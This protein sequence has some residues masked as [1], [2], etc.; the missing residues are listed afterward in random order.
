MLDRCFKRPHIVQALRAGPAGPLLDEFATALLAKGYAR[1]G[2]A[3]YVRAAAHLGDWAS[4]RGIMIAD[5]DEE[6][7]AAFVRH[8][9]K[10]RCLGTEHRGYA[11]TPSR[12]QMFLHYLQRA[13]LVATA[14]SEHTCA[15]VLVDAYCKWMRHQRGATE[16]TISSYLWLIR[17][18]LAALGSDP[19]R[20]NARSI[21]SFVLA[22]VQ[23]HERHSGANVTAAVRSFLR[24]LV[25]RGE[26]STDLI[27][28]VPMVPSRRLA[29][30]PLYLHAEAIEQII[31]ACPCDTRTGLRDR[32][33]LLLLARIG[34][35]A[36]DVVGL[37]LGDIDWRKGRLRVAGK[38]RRETHLPLPQDAGDAVLVYLK[39]ARPTAADDHVFLTVQAPFTRLR[40]SSLS[41]RVA[42]AIR[43]AG[44]DAPSHGAHLLRHSLATR[45]LREG[46]TLDSIGV[47]LRHLNVETTAI[48]A[49][50]DVELLLQIAQPWPC[51][52]VSSC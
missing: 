22:R 37:R 3:C 41:C 47:V 5:L 49:K 36:G 40:A 43:R 6:V 12:V 35:R 10:C 13:G 31:D 2:A 48:Y 33:M 21:R 17:P 34:L 14:A 16:T 45:M 7:V 27:G 23:E 38:G 52:E 39:D 46:A 24:F 4:H 42:A 11:R 19:R 30:L 26:C 50:V 32:A 28:A 20:Y 1:R 9:P 29:K 51:T 8:L 15:S 25:A 18:M 44:V